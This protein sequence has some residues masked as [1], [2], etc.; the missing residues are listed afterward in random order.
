MNTEQLMV[1]AA[2]LNA[3]LANHTINVPITGK[4]GINLTTPTGQYTVALHH[5]NNGHYDQRRLIVLVAYDRFG[6]MDGCT[7]FD[8]W[9]LELRKN[10]LPV[11]RARLDRQMAI[12][13]PMDFST[14][15]TLQFL[16]PNK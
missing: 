10:N 8:Q 6:Q 9:T 2:E 16:P 7:E 5:P 15:Y 13:G 11:A 3:E 1:I 4:L 14:G 12:I